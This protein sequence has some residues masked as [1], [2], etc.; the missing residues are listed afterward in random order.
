[1]LAL[2]DDSFDDCVAASYDCVAAVP[3]TY[4]NVVA[5]AVVAYLPYDELSLVV[6]LDLYVVCVAVAS[7]L[8]CF[9]SSVVVVL[10]N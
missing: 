10:V 8:R 1:M 3:L 6:P 2:T 4:S 9:F 7:C 5:V